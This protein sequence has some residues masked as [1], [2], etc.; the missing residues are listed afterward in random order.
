MRI[1]VTKLMGTRFLTSRLGKYEE[2]VILKGRRSVNDFT[3]PTDLHGNKSPIH[4]CIVYDV[5]FG[6]DPRPSLLGHE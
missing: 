6:I 2:A 3:S 4:A 5:K 1:T